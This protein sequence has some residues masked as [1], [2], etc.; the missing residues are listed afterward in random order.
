MSRILFA[1]ELGANL[2]HL[3]RDLP[4]ASALRA[5]GHGVFFAVRD[6]RV[7]VETLNPAH[8]RFTQAPV[9][10]GRTRLAAPPAN[11]AELLAAE[12]WQDRHA[13]L[14]QIGAWRAL[15]ALGGFDAV[16]ADHAPGA[17]VA[18]R[19]AGRPGIAFGSGFEI[20]PDVS[21]MPAIRPWEQPSHERLLAAERAVL[22][23][24]NAVVKALGGRPYARLGEIF[25]SQPI[26]AT[27]GELD[28]Y[29]ERAGA[30]YV[31]AIDG[32]DN[33]AQVGWPPG[34]GPRILAY[35]RPEHP[36]LAATLDALAAQAERGARAVCAIPGV[37]AALKQG[38]GPGIAVHDRAVALGPLLAEADALVGYGS[39]GTLAKAL[40]YGVPLLMLPATVEQYLGAKRAEA[41]GAGLMLEGKPDAARIGAALGAL[42]EETRY[43]IAARDF[44][45]RHG[46][47]DTAQ[48][49]AAAVSHIEAALAAKPDGAPRRYV[50]EG[51]A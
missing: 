18:A 16:V 20:P 50:L 41:L 39:H 43:R 40:R 5:A 21:P 9:V 19:I 36:A 22:A 32:L 15:V 23:D 8:F 14:G 38:A 48:A 24:L 11:Y 17:L 10:A 27:C 26:L 30:R 45:G 3:A 49:V 42:S 25:G 47:M 34:D 13:L 29:G 33:A 28:H 31:G 12:G 35:L 37:P 2:G 51:R 4:V 6:T 7:A 44:A 46:A 1:W